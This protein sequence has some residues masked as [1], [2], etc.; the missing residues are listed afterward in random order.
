MNALQ[1]IVK[2]PGALVIDKNLIDIINTIYPITFLKTLFTSFHELDANGSMNQ[3]SGLVYYIIKP[4][5]SNCQLVNPLKNQQ[6]IIIFVPDVNII[7]ARIFPH[8]YILNIY[9][10]K[11]NNLS[12]FVDDS[13]NNIINGLEWYQEKYGIFSIIQGLGKTSSQIVKRLSLP[14]SK[15]VSQTTR[16][17]IIDRACDYL[18]PLLKSKTYGGLIK[19]NDIKIKDNLYEKLKYDHVEDAVNFIQHILKT[20]NTRDSLPEIKSSLKKISN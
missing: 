14:K 18:T 5:I 16:L 19:E 12:L 3:K 9:F 10:Y 8:C 17:I 7:C 20:I 1:L 6:P 13:I 4:T 11:L 2:Q 15:E